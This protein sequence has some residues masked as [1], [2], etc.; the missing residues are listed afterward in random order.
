MNLRW[1]FCPLLWFKQVRYG[2][3]CK[4]IT[5]SRECNVQTTILGTSPWVECFLPVRHPLWKSYVFSSNAFEPSVDY[6]RRSEL[7][8]NTHL[9]PSRK[10]ELV[11]TVNAPAPRILI[12]VHEQQGQESCVGSLHNITQHPPLSPFSNVSSAARVAASNTS[13][14]P[15]PVSD[16]HSKYFRAPISRA[17]FV[18]SFSVKNRKDFLRI[19]SCAI[20]S[21]RRSFFRP[22][23]MIGTP[24][25]R[26]LASSTH[27]KRLAYCRSGPQRVLLRALCLTLSNES[28]VSIEKPI[29]MTCAFE[30]AKGRNLS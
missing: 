16:E 17:A 28:G 11:G 25:H 3:A 12:K 2:F 24:G 18:P 29:K 19:S 23:R 4:G 30:Y 20:G 6:L 1:T 22:T 27:C 7:L 14:T 13:S 15:S 10:V 9:T 8:P 5:I 26:S 21:S